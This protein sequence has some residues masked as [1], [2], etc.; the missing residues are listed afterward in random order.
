MNAALVTI[1][2]IEAT[3]IIGLLGWVGSRLWIKVD[4]L[5]SSID[6]LHTLYAVHIAEHETLDKLLN[7]NRITQRKRPT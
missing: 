4:R 3:V 5:G 7:E 6:Q 1:V 2:S